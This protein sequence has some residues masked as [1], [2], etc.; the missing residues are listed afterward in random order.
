MRCGQQTTT[1]A[2]GGVRIKKVPPG[3]QEDARR[4]LIH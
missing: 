4:D 3:E 1:G 2:A